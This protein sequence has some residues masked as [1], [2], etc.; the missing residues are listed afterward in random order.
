MPKRPARTVAWSVNIVV[1]SRREFWIV[2]LRKR[3]AAA[4]EVPQTTTPLPQRP[5]GEEPGIYTG[6]LIC[7]KM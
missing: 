2:R 4:A 5:L 7:W 1:R 6:Y 3:A